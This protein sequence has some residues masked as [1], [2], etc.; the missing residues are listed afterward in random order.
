MVALFEDTERHEDDRINLEKFEL[1]WAKGRSRRA[2]KWIFLR[3][4][5]KLVVTII[6]VREPL[7][8]SVPFRGSCSLMAF[9]S[10]LTCSHSFSWRFNCEAIFENQRRKLID[11]SFEIFDLENRKMPEMRN[12]ELPGLST[13][14]FINEGR[15]FQSRNLTANFYNHRLE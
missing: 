12:Y 11:R 2:A 15:E 7:Q 14:Q 13:S 1:H 5:E 9:P 3:S 8:R 10:K 4:E 6:R